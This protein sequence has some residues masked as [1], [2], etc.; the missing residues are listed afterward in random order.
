MYEKKID[1]ITLEYAIHSITDLSI[2]EK[3]VDPSLTYTLNFVYFAANV[4]HEK[5][6]MVCCHTTPRII[7]PIITI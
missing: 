6:Y 2:R 7:V 3:N 5:H 4:K 1:I